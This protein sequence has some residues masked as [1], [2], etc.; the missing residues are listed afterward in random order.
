MSTSIS[1]RK[2]VQSV[3]GSGAAL[4][5]RSAF[6]QTAEKT[7]QSATRSGQGAQRKDR[8]VWVAR[9]FP[10]KQVRL[11]DGPFKRQMEIN[12]RYLHELPND[13]LL[14]TFRLTA[15]LSTSAQPLGGWEAPKVELRGHLAGGHYLSA[16]ALTVANT[17]DTDLKKKGDELV[18]ELAKCQKKNGGGYLSAF[19]TEEFDRLRAGKNVWAPFYT[20]HKVMAGLLDMATLTGNDEALAMA[21]GMAGWVARWAKPLSD[22][23][24]QR[25][26]NVEYGGMNDVLYNLFALTGREEYLALG[27]RFNHRAF[28]DPL[29]ERRDEL[30]GLHVNTHIPQVIGAARRYE[31][32]GDRRYHDIADYFWYEVTRRRS[33]STGNTSNFEHWNSAPDELATELSPDSA[34]CCCAYNMLKL[35]R[36]L[37]GWTGDASLMDYTER[38]LVNSRLGT[39]DPDGLKMYYYPL[40]AGFWK[41]YGTAFDSFW[42][43]TGTGMEEF[44]KFADTVY[45]HDAGSLTVN[46]F[47]ASE[48]DWPEKGLRVRQET[49]FPEEEAT[50]LTFAS[51]RPVKLAVNIRAPEW[52]WG[53]DVKLNGAPQNLFSAPGTFLTIERTW[54]PGDKLE[55]GFKMHLTTEPVPGDPTLQA[56]LYGPIVLAGEMGSEGLTHEMIYGPY[57][58]RGKPAA[59]PAIQIAGGHSPR[60]IEPVKGEP[61]KFQT[62]EQETTTRLIPLYQIAN[63]R[64][65]VYW[66]VNSANI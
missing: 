53:L 28:F 40:A 43:C 58:P 25:I 6:P 15:G 27:D 16:C 29:A 61:L 33:Y 35:T 62:L 17:G 45:F 30:K 63:E 18:G 36:H 50:T 14:H 39:Q 46:L 34:E 19:P 4:A 23:Q 44:A 5:A 20:Y 10:L 55:I 24:L 48:L 1:R 49:M 38:A 32:T 9:P 66:K 64:Y 54:Q 51:N 52:A 26:L 37:F 42:C 65:V 57:G 60:W 41:T 11:L 22:A 21:E 47:I 2:F 59:A 13:R 31:L 56:A 3:V 12:T 7:E 8:I